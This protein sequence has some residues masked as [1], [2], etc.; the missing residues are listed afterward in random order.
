MNSAR[1]KADESNLFVVKDFLIITLK[2]IMSLLDSEC[3][4]LFLFDQDKKE[5]V[6]DSYFNSREINVKNIKKRAGEGVSGKVMEIKAPVLVRDIDSDPRFRKNGFSH[7]RTKSF[8]SI[9]LLNGKAL[10]GLINVA[11]KSTG[12][13]FSEKDLQFAVCLCKYAC[14]ALESMY[15]STNLSEE[16]QELEKKKSL[17]EKYASVGKLAAGVVHEINNPLDGIIRYTN[18]L[19]SQ[20]EHNSVAKDYLLEIK[21][22]LSRIGNITKSLLEFSHLINS[23]SPNFKKNVDINYLIDEVLNVLKDKAANIHIVKKYGSNL[24]RVLDMGVGLFHVLINLIK[25]AID[26]MPGGGTLEIT[27]QVRDSMLYIS[28]KDTGTGIPQ[29]IKDRI[30]EPFFTTK[31]INKGTGLGLAICSEIINKYEGVI[32][33]ES[34]PA[35]GSVFTV[36]IPKKYLQN[37]Q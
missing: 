23:D 33:V 2:E 9:P 26:A 27:T 4:S 18:L 7:Y 14:V 36:L 31:N 20:I 10:V 12:E 37:V 16:K 25:N 22:G 17:L 6:L 13:A 30:F 24:P 15:N 19:L 1:L 29:E 21:N 28:L 3:G 35:E 32:K 5:L 34:S 8:I 11:D